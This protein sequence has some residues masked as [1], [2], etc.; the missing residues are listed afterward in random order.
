MTTCDDCKHKRY[1]V[2]VAEQTGRC[3]DCGAEGRMMFVVGDPVTLERDRC[4]QIVR[5]AARHG[6]ACSDSDSLAKLI[7]AANAADKRHG[8]VLREGSA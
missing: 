2:D 5:E 8:T 1:S 3:I 7:L 6:C 4:A